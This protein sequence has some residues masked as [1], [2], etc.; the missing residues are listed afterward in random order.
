MVGANGA[1]HRRTGL[2]R[3][4]KRGVKR[5]MLGYVVLDNINPRAVRVNPRLN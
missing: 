4:N 3:K 1:E 5:F 2:L